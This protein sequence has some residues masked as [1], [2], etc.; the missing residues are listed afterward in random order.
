[1][2]ICLES[3]KQPKSRRG[4]SGFTL[5]ELLI[6]IVVLGV[7]AAVVVF[8]LGGITGQSAQ[9]ACNAD[10]KSM[11]VAVAAYHTQTSNWPATGTSDSDFSV[12]TTAD[13]SGNKYLNS[14]PNN[15]AHYAITV[16]P[17]NGAISVAAPE[18]GVTGG[19]YSY[20]TVTLY[21]SQTASP[22]TGCYAVK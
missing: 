12:L 19:V 17:S 1:M 3:E 4:E 5:I 16:D 6:V 7:L 2:D 21:D 11:E 10:A 9:S 18:T 8:A 14:A 13:A 22:A 15:P 20:G